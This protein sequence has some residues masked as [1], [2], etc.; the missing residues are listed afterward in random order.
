MS[1]SFGATNWM[2]KVSDAQYTLAQANERRL[3]RQLPTPNAVRI[4]A[5]GV[6]SWRLGWRLVACS[7]PPSPTA[8]AQDVLWRSDL[9]AALCRV[10][11]AACRWTDTSIEAIQNMPS[12]RILRTLDF[13]AMMTIAY[14]LNRVEREAVARFLGKPGGDPSRVPR[15]SAPI[16]RCR[17]TPARLR[18][19]T[20]GVPSP[21]NSRFAPAALAKLTAEQVPKLKLK[22]AFGFEGDISAF[23]QPTVIGN[24]V[25]IGSAGGVVHALRAGHRLPAVDVP[26]CGLDSIRDRG[27]ASSTA[28]RSAVW[29]PH[30]LVLRT[31]R[32]DGQGDLAQAA[33]GARGGPTEC[34]SGRRRWRRLRPASSWEESRALNPSTRAARSAAASRRCACAMAASSGR[35][36]RSR[37]RRN[38]GKD[39]DRRRD[40]GAIRRR[41]LVHAHARPEAATA[42]RDDRQQLLAA[43]HDDERCR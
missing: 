40:V 8:Y 3:R 21:N 33:R 22:W 35:R 9:Q 23:A 15:R 2:E 12:S 36:T 6:G 42:L 30:R 18:S 4:G 31:R 19:G 39:T 43:G 29:R 1:L 16:V 27:H 5:L 17:S 14:Q 25:F 28:A 38:D 32:R 34:A 13:G 11:R 7:S 10:S 26:G 20:A 24:Q 37:V 41:N